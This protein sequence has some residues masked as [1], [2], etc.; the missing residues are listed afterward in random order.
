MKGSIIASY[1]GWEYA[2]AHIPAHLKYTGIGG[3]S[4]NWTLKEW[5]KTS[6][7]GSFR[8]GLTAYVLLYN[9][10]DAI[11]GFSE[12]LEMDENEFRAWLEDIQVVGT[13]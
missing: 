7:Y 5:V 1:K 4:G 3:S 6:F 13:M 9:V 10:Q 11:N 12:L 2:D 8:M